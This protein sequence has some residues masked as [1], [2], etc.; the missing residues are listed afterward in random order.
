M[1]NRIFFL[2]LSAAL[3]GAGYVY[4]ERSTHVRVTDNAYVNAEVAQI[5]GLVGGRVIAMHVKD[6]QFVKKG[7]QIGRAH[8]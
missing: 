1:V 7:D 3:G 5:S 8:V 2:L 6:N 4:W